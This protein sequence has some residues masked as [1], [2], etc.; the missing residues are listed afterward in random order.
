VSTRQPLATERAAEKAILLGISTDLVTL[1]LCSVVGIWSGSLTMIADCLRGVILVSFSV[2][3]LIAL[4]RINR[5]YYSL[6]D[7]G[8]GK[9]EQMFSLVVSLEL[10][11]A[12]AAL[13]FKAFERLQGEPDAA[14]GSAMVLAVA[15]VTLNF[16]VNGWQF[17]IIRK[18]AR[19]SESPIVRSQMASR[20]VKTIASFVVV[21]AVA[22][23][24]LTAGQPLAVWADSLGTLFVAA[25][26]V[27]A[28]WGILKSALP[29][30]LDRTL[31]EDMQT[32][33][34]RHL[35]EH[36]DEYD[37]LI[38]VRSRRTGT[39]VLIELELG[40]VA[41]MTIG[42]IQPV[43]DAL[44]GGIEADIPNA[45]ATVIPRSVPQGAA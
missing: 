1:A 23:A 3:S 42:A 11:C 41:S 20:R 24:G 6:Y 27:K 28:A 45:R 32:V 10:A 4:R 18:A 31:D 22:M 25:Y 30:L 39:A 36:F 26:M 12:A 38:R 8:T 15:L 9:L 34:N 43:I 29:D 2:F 33:I 44:R 37:N 16:V 14:N 17:F 35:A 7:Y 40:F 13:A 5:G 19:N 21:I